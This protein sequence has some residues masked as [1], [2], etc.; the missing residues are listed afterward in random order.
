MAL[1]TTLA[2]LSQTPASNA[3]DGATDAPSTIDN[4]MNLLA[5]F[6]AQLR[7][8]LGNY[9]SLK[10]VAS[11]TVMDATYCGA[12]TI[13]T[14]GPYTLTLPA[15]S[16][17]QPS[18]LATICITNLS[19]ATQTLSRAGTDTITTPD[20]AGYTTFSL[21]A[22]E[23]ITLASN[24]TNGWLVTGGSV[25]TG[26]SASFKGTT[27][28]AGYQYFPSGLILQYGSIATTAAGAAV[29]FPITYTTSGYSVT[30]G[31]QTAGPVFAT[32]QTLTPTGF[33]AQG[34]T[35]STGVQTDVFVT[36]MALGY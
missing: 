6:T 11:A 26:K 23:T 24:G 4:N 2:S 18:G 14:G 16:V 32:Y 22:G 9:R 28:S 29:T 1:Y 7:D 27:A 35:S 19:T 13:A 36:W 25:A 33:F 8:S 34:W 21:K 15:A 17:A 10:S 12:A 3:A 20:T 30:L 31:T 5:S